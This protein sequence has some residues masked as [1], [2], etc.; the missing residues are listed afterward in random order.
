MRTDP[1]KYSSECRKRQ[2]HKERPKQNPKNGAGKNILFGGVHKP[3]K[4][5]IK[6]QE[7]NSDPK[8]Q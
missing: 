4:N 5:G 2:Q 8:P 6:K 7:R 1:A 3:I